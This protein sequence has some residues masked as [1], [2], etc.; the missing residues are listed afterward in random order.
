[1]K[2][3]V[4]VSQLS[5]CRADLTSS[6]SERSEGARRCGKNMLDVWGFFASYVEYLLCNGPDHECQRSAHLLLLGKFATVVC[7]AEVLFQPSFFLVFSV[8]HA[9]WSMERTTE[10]D[11]A[12]TERKLTR[13]V[14]TASLDSRLHQSSMYRVCYILC[15]LCPCEAGFSKSV[16][17]KHFFKTRP[18]MHDKDHN[19]CIVK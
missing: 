16:E 19:S 17:V 9:E 10:P 4:S 7:C 14:G 8:L 6:F 2:T 3:I 13:L 11:T 12:Q 18:A 5:I 1:M 15:C